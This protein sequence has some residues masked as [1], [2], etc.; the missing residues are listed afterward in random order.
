M[1]QVSRIPNNFIVAPDQIILCVDRSGIRSSTPRRTRYDMMPVYTNIRGSE[2][3]MS[4]QR[5]VKEDLLRQLGRPP[6]QPAPSYARAGR[7][8]RQVA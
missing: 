3:T 8:G 5:T 2:R 4:V 6:S 7:P 1:R